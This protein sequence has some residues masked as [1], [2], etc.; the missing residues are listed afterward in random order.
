MKQNIK[1][2]KKNNENIIKNK[3]IEF[4]FKIL[5]QLT[6]LETSS[7][8]NNLDNFKDNI[9][10]VGKRINEE[11]KEI[12]KKVE[13]E[14]SNVYEQLEFIKEDVISGITNETNL[15]KGE[16][17]QEMKKFRVEQKIANQIEKLKKKLESIEISFYGFCN[18]QLS[19]II[20]LNS[21]NEIRENIEINLGNNQNI[22][23][24]KLE[25]IF[26]TFLAIGTGLLTLISPVSLI[27]DLI[28]FGYP[29]YTLYKNNSK[30]IGDIFKGFK[31][32]FEENKKRFL[33]LF[34]KKKEEIVGSI[35]QF[36]EISKEKIIFLKNNNFKTK[37]NKFIIWIKST[38]E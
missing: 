4:F 16:I 1:L 28:F 11:F 34:D 6:F 27:Y 31:D 9:T 7:E 22:R 15:C 3:F 19:E 14:Y 32:K 30:K 8:Q 33:K 20:N 13:N 29:L 36:K 10:N 24:E 38:N 26:L 21:I 2:S 23:A 25:K 5:Y 12:K 17:K 37:Y 35:T 18:H